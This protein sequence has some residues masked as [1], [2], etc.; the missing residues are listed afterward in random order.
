[1]TSQQEEKQP[2]QELTQESGIMTSNLSVG[3][4]PE[5]VLKEAKETAQALQKVLR[6][7]A[8]P[9]IINKKQYL[10][11]E[12]WQTLAR[13]YGV[14][15]KVTYTAPIQIGNAVGFEAR[16]VALDTRTGLE[17]SAADAMCL[18]DE[19]K[20]G[21]RAKF[22]WKTVA[23]KNVREKVGEEQVPM[24]QLRSMAQTRA[25]AKALRNVL[26]WVVVLAGFAPTPAEE[27]DGVVSDSISAS[28]NSSGSDGIRLMDSKFPGTCAICKTAFGKG[29]PIF[30]DSKTRT[31]SHKMCFEQLSGEDSSSKTEKEVA[32]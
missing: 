29:T 5:V 30:Y 17:I 7:K 6:A 23:G 27:M 2:T 26:A 21:K 28:S 22:E 20:W 12:D 32:E 15:A 9:V 14:T 10:E 31:S 13:F 3:R 19:E 25:C 16:A 18:N 8:K 11:F 1:M 4:P 24:F